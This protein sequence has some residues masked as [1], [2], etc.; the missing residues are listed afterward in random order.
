MP[1]SLVT[2]ATGLLGNNIVREL[3]NRG[4]SVRVLLRKT[5]DPRP[6]EGLDVERVVGEVADRESVHLALEGME[7]VYHSAGHIH[8]GWTK[9]AEAQQ[10]NV[11]GSANVADGALAVGA[12]MVHVSTVDT[13][14]PGTAKTP[15]D[16]DTPGEKTPCTY[17]VT[18]RA[19]EEQVRRRIEQG[20]DC[21]IV[22]PGFM[23]GPW[24]WKPSSGRMFLEVVRRFTPLAPTGGMSI[25]DVRDVAKGI[26]AAGKSGQKGRQYILAGTNMTY[27]DAW[28]MFVK[29][30][31][32][33]KAP[34][35][36]AGPVNRFLGS[37]FGDLTTKLTGRENDVNSAGIKMSRLFHYY[38]SGRAKK[39]LNYQTRDPEDS[40]A[41]AWRWFCDNGY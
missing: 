19:A 3:L 8:I 7:C 1:K 40:A 17:V 31:G 6:L 30:A 24:D 32:K 2:G 13:L 4:D 26:L 29:I 12:R 10:V 18:K 28:K 36:T 21:V 20:L 22:N 16:E 37:F 34:I 14:A 38:N 5:S 27:F 9:R 41:D 23:L 15:A 33:G 25:C 35:A 39:E 11:E